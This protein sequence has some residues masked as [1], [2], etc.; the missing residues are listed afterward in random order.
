MT[1]TRQSRRKRS[2]ESRAEIQIK[3]KSLERS[4]IRR[5]NLL[6]HLDDLPR[7]HRPEDFAEVEAVDFW[8]FGVHLDVLDEGGFGLDAEEH[9]D[10]DE[11]VDVQHF[12]DAFEVCDDAQDVYGLLSFLRGLLK[13]LAV[14]LEDFR[15]EEGDDEHARSDRVLGLRA[16]GGVDELFERAELDDLPELFVGRLEVCFDL[17]DVFVV[18][19]DAPDAEGRLEELVGV[20]EHQAFEQQRRVRV[21]RVVA[22]GDA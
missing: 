6:D 5:I 21:E 20:L 14:L 19:L 7:G 15:E 11:R 4:T 10:S 9:D 18:Q 3:C 22:V 8:C 16:A 17:L 1:G 13:L 2:I 12:A